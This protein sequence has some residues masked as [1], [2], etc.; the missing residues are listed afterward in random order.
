M[1][2]ARDQ[3]APWARCVLAACFVISLPL[4][5]A[6]AGSS[7]AR[8]TLR[9]VHGEVRDA[10][11]GNGIAAASVIFVSD[12]LD[13]A[14]TSTDDDGHFSLAVDVSDAIVFGHVTASHHD[15]EPSAAMSVYFDGTQNALTFELRRK[16]SK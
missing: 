16:A 9:E 15:Y 11:S 7:E 8:S 10:Q 12:A 5:G 4:F 1:L 6:C 13:N 2:F 14:E 3:R